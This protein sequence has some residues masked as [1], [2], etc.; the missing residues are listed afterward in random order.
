[1]SD[2]AIEEII[3]SVMANNDAQVKAYREGKTQLL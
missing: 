1:M 2:E 3:A